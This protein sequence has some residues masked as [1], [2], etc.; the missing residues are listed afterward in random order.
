V[1]DSLAHKE[2]DKALLTGEKYLRKH[3]NIGDQVAQVAGIFYLT[4]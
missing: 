3:M 1:F 2:I 4:A